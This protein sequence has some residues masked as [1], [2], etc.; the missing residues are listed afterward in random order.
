MRSALPLTPRWRRLVA[1]GLIR[2]RRDLLAGGRLHHVGF[3]SRRGRAP[4]DCGGEGR[5]AVGVPG[6]DPGELVD[7]ER[8][9]LAVQLHGRTPDLAVTR[10]DGLDADAAIAVPDG[11]AH[12]RGQ[13]LV[14]Q[15]AACGD[16]PHRRPRADT[17]GL[18]VPGAD[19][20][21]GRLDG[22]LGAPFDVVRRL[23]LAE[24]A[25]PGRSVLHR[26]LTAGSA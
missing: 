8:Y 2:L 5:A 15:R 10:L 6:D 16:A 19:G 22:R 11:G 7:D 4:V 18:H 24:G 26:H 1:E 9:V 20:C 25:G 14:V 12:D 23:G 21:G 3:V 17:V 13:T